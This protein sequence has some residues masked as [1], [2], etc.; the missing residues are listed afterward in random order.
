MHYGIVQFEETDLCSICGLTVCAG[1]LPMHQKTQ[2]EIR[3]STLGSIKLFISD[4]DPALMLEKLLIRI[5]LL[6]EKVS[7]PA[8]TSHF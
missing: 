3:Y 2:H 7:D 4:P 8:P 1:S 6:Q 5:R